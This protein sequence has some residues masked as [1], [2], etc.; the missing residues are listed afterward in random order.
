M[1][2]FLLIT[3]PLSCLLA[4]ACE[5]K[6]AEPTQWNR[7]A[8]N[9]V[10]RDAIPRENYEAASDAHVFYD[11]NQHLKMIYTGD[12]DG[13]P[14][15]K[16]ATGTDWDT[17]QQSATLL[18][19]AGPTGLDSHKETGFYRNTAD[20]T[21]QIYYIGYADEDTYQAQLFLAEAASLSV[22]YA[23]PIQPIVPRGMIAG[24]DVYSITSPSVVAHQNQLYLVFIGW[25]AAPDEVTEVWVIG[26]TSADEG[27]TWTDFQLVDTPIGMEGKV[28]KRSDG[29]FVA[30]RTG[31]YSNREAIFYATAAHPFGPWQTSPGPILVQQGPPLEKDEIIAP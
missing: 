9:P 6:E 11:P 18:D 16:L 31:D 14:A 29:S 25:N 17:W 26:A 22:P 12:S 5:P 15:I 20:R 3:I 10:F 8:N 23:Q 2:G 30:A 1:K 13:K 24:K 27:H 7:V 28:T 4:V 19:G 21:H